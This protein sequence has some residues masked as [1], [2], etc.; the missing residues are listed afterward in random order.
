MGQSIK[1]K[2]FL[3]LTITFATLGAA[4]VGCGDDDDDSG[5]GSS[6]KSG[7]GAGGNNA[8]NSSGGTGNTA[9][10]NGGASSGKGGTETGGTEA[11]GTEAGGAEMGGTGAGGGDGPGPGPGEAGMG[12][13]GTGPV[14]GGGAGA[15]GGGG[16]S[17][18]GGSGGEGGAFGGA[19][20][21]GGAGPQ[22]EGV[23]MTH[24][25]SSISVGHYHLATAD[26]DKNALMA[27]INDD[28]R[29]A[30]FTLTVQGPSM[31]THTITFTSEQI[32]TLRSGGEVTLA[33][34][35]Q[36]INA[37]GSTPPAHTHTYTIKCS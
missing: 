1:R 16:G 4:A 18:G 17:S 6:G 29:G 28:A 23:T 15:E 12:P 36:P 25:A 34:S 20:G 14:G 24:T 9:G 19:A 5:G 35:S 13:G 26:A 8:G 7:G 2:D 21:A 30:T 33:P 11:G 10:N 31:H 22:C 32:T 27:Y 37:V 3:T